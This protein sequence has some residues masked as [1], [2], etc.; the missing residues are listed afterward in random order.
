MVDAIR[1]FFAGGKVFELLIY[2]AIVVIAIFAALR[3]FTP[4]RAKA[5]ALRKATRQI[6]KEAKQE[7][8][9]P[10]WNEARFLGARLQ[11][12][13]TAF[14]Q[15]AQA[16]DTYGETCDV[17]EYINE[18]TV[19]Y[20]DE[21]V[22]LA[23][24]IP[25]VMVSLGIL[26]TFLGL[27]TG[28]SGLT[29]VEDTDVMLG[30]IQQLISGMS[31]A[32]LTSIFGVLASL[33][34]N[35]LNR[36]FT[37]RCQRAMQRFVTTFQRYAMAK[38][39]GDE[40]SLVTLQQEQTAYMRQMVEEVSV[41][42]AAQMEQAILRAMLPMQ[43]SMDNFIIATTR[44]QVE[45]IDRIAA[46]FV[47]RMNKALDGEFAKLGQTLERVRTENEHTQGDMRVA[48][49]A[50]RTM[51][52]DVINMHEL[53][54][55]LLEQFK[56]YVDDMAKQKSSVEKASAANLQALERV[57][58]TVG[59][60]TIYLNKL[61]EYQALLQKSQ[62][63]YLRAADQFL[64][65]VQRQ[66]QASN[67]ELERMSL[68]MEDAAALLNS[69]YLSFAEQIDAGLRGAAG[70]M[71]KGM[72]RAMTQM[73]QAIKAMQEAAQEMSGSAKALLEG[74]EAMGNTSRGEGDA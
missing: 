7:T 33:C 64:A 56:G 41:R 29:L 71:D 21:S 34:F 8:I 46:R 65:G 28:L 62:K 9:P 54:Q 22:N 18:D 72:Q 2:V 43:R 19:V 49:E 32:F 24:M 30:A 44:E 70:T 53:S 16:R 13:W 73:T 59:A 11:G 35:F 67:Q 42:M 1:S 20:A 57:D 74:A 14:L 36:Y 17:E 52:Q 26:G 15:N 3:C 45:G 31:T 10:A 23:E 69:S 47:E 4:L 66:M 48:A 60:Q 38:P 5:K 37:S 6:V 55:G 40:T 50:I 25:G 39:L 58:E 68:K 12:S 51:T 63:D 27:V 61:Q